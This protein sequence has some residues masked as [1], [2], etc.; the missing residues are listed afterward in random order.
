MVVE[1]NL[2]QPVC[3]NLKKQ[4]VELHINPV[5]WCLIK[6]MGMAEKGTTSLVKSFQKQHFLQQFKKLIFR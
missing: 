4:I 5:Y 6:Y 1:I 3:I 2:Y